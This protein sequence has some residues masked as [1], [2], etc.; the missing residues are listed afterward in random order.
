MI[1]LHIAQVAH[2]ATQHIT[3]VPHVLLIVGQIAAKP[4]DGFA[5][6]TDFIKTIR[7]TIV[8]VALV[9]F[10]IG[11]SVG[12]MMR[13]LSF[14]S[15]RRIM[16]SNIAISSAIVGLAVVVLAQVIFTIITNA[17]NFKP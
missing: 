12:A 15:E 8:G 14:G 13:M 16:L 4:G 9:V 1:L 2:H 11:I 17:F 10:F 5:Q 7:S 6:I 3:L